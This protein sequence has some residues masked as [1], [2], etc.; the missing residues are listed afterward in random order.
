[1]SEHGR[2]PEE[3]G[4]YSLGYALEMAKRRTVFS[5]GSSAVDGLLG[6]GFRTGESVEIHGDSGTGKTQLAMQ[7]TLAPVAAGHT[8]AFIDTEGS[9][10]PERLA[11]MAEVRGLD[12]NKALSRVFVVRADSTTLQMEALK[13]SQGLED[14][15]MVVVDT[16]T[17]NF[18]LEYGG[19]AMT[20]RRQ[21]E[22]AA[23]LNRL[24][25]DAVV[26]DRS[27]VLTNRVASVADPGRGAESSE[28]SIGGDT[29]ERAVMKTLGL[30][31]TGSNVRIT[32]A[33][34]EEGVA[35]TRITEKG[36]E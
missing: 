14:C 3:A 7:A 15:R 23:Y 10:R 24:N 33:G 11:Q 4:E 13:K 9:F 34:P 27:L 5:S 22:L 18:T 6:G 19:Q 31:R 35:D 20:G 17:K 30:R 26:H 21:V 36:M 29:L 8:A 32:L 12:S 28:V 25:W 2:R 16:V 1:M